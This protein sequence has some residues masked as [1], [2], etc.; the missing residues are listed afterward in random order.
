MTQEEEQRKERIKTKQFGFN[1]RFDLIILDLQDLPL[2]DGIDQNSW[3]FAGCRQD[4]EKAR[5]RI[6]AYIERCLR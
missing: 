5:T 2:A 3:L 1:E 4:L 6:L